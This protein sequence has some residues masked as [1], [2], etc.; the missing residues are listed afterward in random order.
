[1]AEIKLSV[2]TVSVAITGLTDLLQLFMLKHK[3]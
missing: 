1:M 2:S 3:V